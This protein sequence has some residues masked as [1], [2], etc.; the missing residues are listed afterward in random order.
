MVLRRSHTFRR[1]GV[2]TCLLTVNFN[3]LHFIIISV[4]YRR[5]IWRRFSGLG[6]RSRRYPLHVPHRASRRRRERIST[7]GR[8]DSADGH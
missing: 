4:E 2:E 5:H 6:T 1:Y 7:S 8:R 3:I